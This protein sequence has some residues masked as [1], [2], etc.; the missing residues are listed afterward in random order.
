MVFSYVKREERGGNRGGDGN[1]LIT[2]Q[3]YCG[4]ARLLGF[5]AWMYTAGEFAH[6]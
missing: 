1:C 6:A 3:A 4:A 5:K 2:V